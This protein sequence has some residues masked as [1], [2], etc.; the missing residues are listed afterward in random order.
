MS[1]TPDIPGGE[2]PI[3]PIEPTDF[4]ES[5]EATPAAAN[6]NGLKNGKNGAHS[7]DKPK[8]GNG[9]GNGKHAV[10]P[11]K[12]NGTDNVKEKNG[13]GIN[14][15]GRNGSFFSDKRFQVGILAALVIASLGV[16]W[17]IFQQVSDDNARDL[18]APVGE[19]DPSLV[20][21]STGEPATN[22]PAEITDQGSE[23]LVNP[24]TSIPNEA[25]GDTQVAGEAGTTDDSEVV[26]NDVSS[27]TGDV[28]LRERGFFDAIFK[29]RDP[30]QTPNP[31]TEPVSGSVE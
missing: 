14:G 25:T 19:F 21:E 31:V 27:V 12:V 15:N 10:D 7:L 5:A 28:E 18:P 17:V 1:D 29:F 8:N 23:P 2:G 22:P 11:P 3:D 6:G 13:N 9:N 20:T 16:W 26:I 30:F 4:A 24:E